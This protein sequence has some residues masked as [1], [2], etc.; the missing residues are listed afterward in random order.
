MKT[1]CK[2]GRD[3]YAIKTREQA[4]FLERC[5][6]EQKESMTLNPSDIDEGELEHICKVL[7]IADTSSVVRL[8]Y[9]YGKHCIYWA[10]VK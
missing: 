6:D 4:E 1:I 9:T 2:I 5:I 10:Q 7:K 3:V 8:G